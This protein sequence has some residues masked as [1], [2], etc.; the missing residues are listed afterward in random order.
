MELDVK[1]PPTRNLKEAWGVVI[2]VPKFDAVRDAVLSSLECP[3]GLPRP[4]ILVP[5]WRHQSP[6]WVAA[7]QDHGRLSSNEPALVCV[8]GELLPQPLEL[9][10]LQ[11]LSL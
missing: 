1:S 5:I 8:D 4:E 6:E 11:Q 10:E 3:K 7:Y 9:R 2:R